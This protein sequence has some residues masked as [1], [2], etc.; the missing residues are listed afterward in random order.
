MTNL[1]LPVTIKGGVKK[2]PVQIL[3]VGARITVIARSV[4][5]ENKW[6]HYRKTGD[7]K[8]YNELISQVKEELAVLE[9]NNVR[10]SSGVSSGERDAGRNKKQDK[11]GK[12][13]RVERE[14]DS[15]G[16]HASARGDNSTE[17]IGK[18]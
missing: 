16:V 11:P 15:T 8:N 4:P 7:V 2:I 1:Q 18:E 10:R 3:R 9:A 14:G 13:K 17:G 6:G 12:T 5:Q